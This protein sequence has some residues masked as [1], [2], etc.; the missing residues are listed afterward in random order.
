MA[1][2]I[3]SGD[4]RQL[5]GALQLGYRQRAQGAAVDMGQQW[6]QIEECEINLPT[7]QVD[8]RRRCALVGYMGDVCASPLTE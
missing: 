1:E 5:F 7:Q 3:Q 4:V 8:D 2:L 6:R